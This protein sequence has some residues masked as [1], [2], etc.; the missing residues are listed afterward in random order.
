MMPNPFGLRV[1]GRTTGV[2]C[3]AIPSVDVVSCMSGR[4]VVE[5]CV[6]GWVVDAEGS[7]CIREQSIGGDEHNPRGIASQLHQNETE[8]HSVRPH[9]NW[10]IADYRSVIDRADSVTPRDASPI[11]FT[12]D[13]TRIPDYRR[14]I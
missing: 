6:S 2:D 5:S 1:N 10:R 8:S 14:R 13:W 11:Q 3:T 4:C 12:E 7:G 9:S